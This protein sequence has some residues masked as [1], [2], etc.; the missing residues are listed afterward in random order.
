MRC[1][2]RAG[3]LAEQLEL[4]LAGDAAQGFGRGMQA[5]GGDFGAAID[6][7]AVHAVLDALE[8]GGNGVEL[9]TFACVEREFEIALNVDMGPRVFRMLKVL[10]RG[11]DPA[12]IATT[13]TDQLG[14]QAG[15]L[16][17]QLFFERGGEV[18]GHENLRIGQIHHAPVQQARL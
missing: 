1:G 8:G 14:Q 2:S 5:R 17:Q 4:A 10:G 13:Q 12:D 15:A 16:L 3:R 11:L 7:D 18:L 9:G 6:A